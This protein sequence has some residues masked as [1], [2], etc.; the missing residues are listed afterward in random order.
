MRTLQQW[1]DDYGVSHQNSTNKLIHW[2][3]V[4]SIMFSIIGML[5]AIP[6]PFAQKA[7]ITN[8]AA[9]VLLGALI[10]YLRLSF[11]MFISMAI[12]MLG[13][14]W[15]N[16]Q[17]YDRGIN[18]LLVSM[19]IFVVAWIGQFWGHKIEGKKPSFL[20][21]IQFL[22][23]GPAWLMHFIYKKLGWNY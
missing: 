17:L 15:L 7:F 9:V 23:I 8:W 22:L 18:L 2:L 6:F 5:Y 16:S 11:A 1:L 12:I 3:C 20:N 4:P 19:V 21:D 14:L 10:F 13:M